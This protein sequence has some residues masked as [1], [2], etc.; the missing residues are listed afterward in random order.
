MPATKPPAGRAVR[1]APVLHARLSPRFTNHQVLVTRLWMH[2]HPAISNSN[3]T[4]KS[5][6][7]YVP[8][9]AFKELGFACTNWSAPVYNDLLS[10]GDGTGEG[11]VR[12]YFSR[13]GWPTFLPTNEQD[14]F[15]RK[16]HELKQTQLEDMVKQGSI[17]LRADVDRVRKHNA[18]PWRSGQ[19]RPLEA[20]VHQGLNSCIPTAEH[21]APC[22][23]ACISARHNY[24]LLLL[25]GTCIV[26][27]ATA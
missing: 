11:L 12:A 21:A 23:A 16:V 24:A 5:V 13:V 4:M 25:V 3:T 20:A 1:L 10:S 22:G 2:H 18:W 26:H 9:R 6:N 14:L 19:A 8:H 7:N 15:T 27:V 17:P